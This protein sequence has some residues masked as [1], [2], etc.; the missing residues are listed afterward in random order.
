MD[1]CNVVYMEA[2]LED[3]SEPAAGPQHNEEGSTGNMSVHPCN[4]IAA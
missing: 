2:A 4:N 3:Y 1:N